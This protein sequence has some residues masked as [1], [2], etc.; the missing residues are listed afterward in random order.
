MIEVGFVPQQNN[1]TVD[2]I[3]YKNLTIGYGCIGYFEVFPADLETEAATSPLR[4]FSGRAAF[5]F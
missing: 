5:E 4:K 2:L 1:S 3:K